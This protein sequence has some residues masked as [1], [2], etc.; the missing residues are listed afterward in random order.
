MGDDLKGRTAVVT[1]ASGGIGLETAKGLARLG[2]AVTL[3]GRDPARL[4]AARAE[5]AAVA[6]GAPPTTA[7]CD[8]ASLA[9]VRR[10]ATELRQRL[11][12]LDV[13]VNNAGAMNTTR[14]LS[15]DGHEL[16]FAVNHLAT[17]LLTRELLPSLKAARSPRVVTVASEAHRMGALDFDDLGSAGTYSGFRVYGT[18][19]LCNIL[20]AR[21]L[22]RRETSVAS[23]SLHPGV[24]AT[25]FGRNDAGWYRR[26]FGAVAPF[27]KTPAQGARTSIHLAASPSVAGVTGSYFKDEREARPRAAALDAA[28]AARLWEVSARM[29]GLPA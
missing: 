17:Y 2:A 25:G 28:A 5:V 21:E 20:F 4:E 6:T 18:S 3:V 13:L 8:L 19:K 26:L 22:A 24:V 16:T 7:R 1:G 27:L 12:V 11:P 10:L 29:T 9:A 23:N 15:A 14:K